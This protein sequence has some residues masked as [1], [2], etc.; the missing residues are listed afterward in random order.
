MFGFKDFL[1]VNLAGESDIIEMPNN[2]KI[3]M[4]KCLKKCIGQKKT[5]APDRVF[6]DL[7]KLIKAYST[8]F[9]ETKMS[10]ESQNHIEN[11]LEN[12]Y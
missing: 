2:L 11:V 9:G 7:M 12:F 8:F 3:A 4:D 10:K 1:S 6:D 5:P